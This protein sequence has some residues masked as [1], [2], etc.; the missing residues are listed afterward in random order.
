MPLS[1]PEPEPVV[2]PGDQPALAIM[3][4]AATQNRLALMP[5]PAAPAPLIGPVQPSASSAVPVVE[6]KNEVDPMPDDDDLVLQVWS[7]THSI[8]ILLAFGKIKIQYQGK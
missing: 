6:A 2:A 8:S 3:P 5:P 1:F 4:S 7:L